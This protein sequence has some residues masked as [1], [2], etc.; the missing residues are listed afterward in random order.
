[1][2]L[3]S[4]FKRKK[5]SDICIFVEC[6][7]KNNLCSASCI[8]KVLNIQGKYLKFN[9][10]SCFD[11]YDKIFPDLNMSLYIKTIFEG[12]YPVSFDKLICNFY[13]DIFTQDTYS[14]EGIIFQSSLYK[15][16]LDY[17]LNNIV[18]YSAEIDEKKE[19]PNLKYIVY[20]NKKIDH[21]EISGCLVF[22]DDLEYN[23]FKKY[24]EH[25]ISFYMDRRPKLL[26][27]C[28]S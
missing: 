8:S 17:I 25:K 9:I 15:L 27:Q 2:F 22:Y 7:D 21:E 13:N 10:N 6:K 24:M 23:G 18:S 28:R 26:N 16:N 11:E 14:T 4:L 1:M 19:Y 5:N 20:F 3:K 12:V